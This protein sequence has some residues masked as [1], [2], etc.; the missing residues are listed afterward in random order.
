MEGC[1]KTGITSE[2]LV[3]DEDLR[4]AVKYFRENGTMTSEQAKKRITKKISL[5]KKYSV[6][7]IT[8]IDSG[9][10]VETDCHLEF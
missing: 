5:M 7:E 8:L 10:V 9:Q 1:Q 6:S 4:E 2:D 3:N